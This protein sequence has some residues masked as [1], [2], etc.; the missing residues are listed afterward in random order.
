MDNRDVL[1]IVPGLLVGGVLIAG[2]YLD[3]NW[4]PNSPRS[5]PM[6]IL[7]G[8]NPARILTIAFG[9]LIIAVTLLGAL[10]R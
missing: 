10:L 6:V 5:E 7:L 3:W 4:L 2:G 1:Q 9:L 8:R